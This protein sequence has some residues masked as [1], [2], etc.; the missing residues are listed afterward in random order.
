MLQSVTIKA[1]PGIQKQNQINQVLVNNQYNK[2]QSLQRN[3]NKKNPSS[4][5]SVKFNANVEIF[6][7]ESWKKY[8]TDA[9]NETEYT[10]KKN[11][12]MK[13]KETQLLASSMV[14]GGSGCIIN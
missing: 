5:K 2:E 1:V 8:N 11:E 12:I 9:A 14:Y 6:K 3:N 7:V 4:K 13:M 10:R